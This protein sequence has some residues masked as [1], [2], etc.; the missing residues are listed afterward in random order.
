MRILIIEDDE[1]IA[2]NLRLML[3]RS[4]YA[5]DV[6]HT[7]SEGIGKA[8]AEA[9]DLVILDWMLPDIEGPEVISQ[10]RREKIG[11]P[12]LMLTA[13]SELDDTVAGLDA[14]A[15]DYLPKPF[16][17]DVLLARVRALLRRTSA[18]VAEPIMTIGDVVIDTNA[19]AV[20]R[21]NR[22]ILLAPKEFA[23]L[24]YLAVH[25]NRAI[26]RMTIL[27][28]VWDENADLFSNTV[29]VHI[30]Y[31]RKKIERV[32]SKQLIRTVKGKGY[33]LCDT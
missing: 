16:S 13:R 27:S 17:F 12:I 25:K 20:R 2:K 4:S 29:D 3:R 8:V 1:R 21:G 7:G 14:G 11:A 26:D 15:D 19:N 22:D 30:R 33:M 10:L 28:H 6:A 32:S 18:S 9:Y 24:R 23:L 5:A 31:L